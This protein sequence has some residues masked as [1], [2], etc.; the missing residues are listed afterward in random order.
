MDE[1][2]V[3]RLAAEAATLGHP[4]AKRA[5]GEAPEPE[6]GGAAAAQSR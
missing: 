1:E 2:F 4:G 6:T 3:A 5:L